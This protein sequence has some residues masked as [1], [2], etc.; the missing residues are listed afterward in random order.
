MIDELLSDAGASGLRTIWSLDEQGVAEASDWSNLG[1]EYRSTKPGTK[2][3][4]HTGEKEYFKGGVRHSKDYDREVSHTAATGEKRGRGRP[5]KSQFES[6]NTIDR[7]FA[8]AVG[9]DDNKEQSLNY[10]QDQLRN[11]IGDDLFAELQRSVSNGDY[12]FSDD[13]YHALYDHYHDEM[14]QGTRKDHDGD[15]YEWIGDKLNDVFADDSLAEG[16]WQDIDD[17][18][19][20]PKGANQQIKTIEPGSAIKVDPNYK[21]PT[22]TKSPSMVDKAASTAGRTPPYAPSKPTKTDN[23]MGRIVQGTWQADPKGTVPAPSGDPEGVREGDPGDVFNRP[24]SADKPGTTY[25]INGQRLSGAEWDAAHKAEQ[26]RPKSD[27]EN[28]MDA[29]AAQSRDKMLAKQATKKTD[30]KEDIIMTNELAEMMRLAGMTEG[31]K[32]KPDYLDFDKDGNKKEPMKSALKD[33]KVDESDEKADKDYDGDGEVESGKDEY[34]GSKIAAAKKAGKLKEGEKVKEEKCDECGMYE[35]KCKCD[36][37][38]SEALNQMRRIAGLKECDM[39]PVATGAGEM[40]QQQGKMNISTN[41]S[42][43]GTK[44]VTISAD[45]DSALELMQM[46]KLAGMGGGEG[47][48][49]QEPE[50]VMVVAQDAGEESHEEEVDETKDPRYHANTTPEEHVYPEQVLTRG[51]N[52]EVA[53]RN[54]QM[55]KDGYQFG[56][57]PMAMKES[58]GLKFMKEYEGIKVKK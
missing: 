56:D 2:E 49:H 17:R 6:H 8:E 10:E 21:E 23:G 12:D 16:G 33:K 18:S 13:L 11:S 58:M 50:G 15:P 4:T 54:K 40:Q 36:E 19:A 55:H 9:D 3:P 28:E 34:L 7:L 14:P 41:M 46:L 20:P 30:Q 5:K 37:S 57:N 45:G 48:H 52:G 31:K 39:S 38:V 51:G 42:S 26:D 1:A 22:T 29:F 32:A 47:M 44:N 25:E 27:T 43:D 53:G 24:S 35:S